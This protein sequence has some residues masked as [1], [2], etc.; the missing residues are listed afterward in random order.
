MTS[1]AKSGREVISNLTAVDRRLTFSFG[2]LILVLMLSALTAAV[3]YL[4]GVMKREEQQLSTLLTQVLSVSVSRVSFSGRYH[5]QLLLEDIL[6]EHP[7]IRYLR[8]TDSQGRVLAGN[9]E[10]LIDTPLLGAAGEQAR[11]ALTQSGAD[12]SRQLKMDGEPILEVTL[13]Y[14]GGFDHSIQGVVQV[15]ISEASRVAALRQGVFYV[16]GV[17]LLLLLIG[18]LAVHRLSRLFGLPVR[19]LAGDM[20][21]TLEALPDILFELDDQGR[22]VEVLAH[23]NELLLNTRDQLIGRRI[24][25]VLPEEAAQVLTEALQEAAKK[26]TSTGQQYSLQV[27]GDTYWFELSIARKQSRQNERPCFIVLA[28]DITDRKLAEESLYLFANA[29]KHSGEAILITDRENRIVTVNPALIR[30]TGYDYDELIGKNPRVLASGHASRDTYR[31]MWASLKESGY[32]QGE[33]WDRNKNGDVYPKWTAISVIRNAHNEVTHYIASYTD[34]TERKAAE[35]RIEFIAHHDVLTGLFN[36]YSLEERLEQTL[37][38]AHRKGERVAV[39][40]I[41]MDRF[42]NINDTLGHHSGDSLLVE[43]GRR[44]SREVR[45]SDI[46]ARLGGDEFIVVLNDV[47]SDMAVG[48]LAAQLVSRL[49]EAYQ[50]EEKLLHITASIGISMFP[51][52]GDD[53]ETLMKHADAAMYHAKDKGRNNFQFFTAAMNLA[54]EERMVIENEMR[55]ALNNGEFELHYQPISDA[56]GNWG[57]FEALLRWRHPQRGLIAPGLFIPIAEESRLI[58]PIG[59]WVIEEACRQS[60]EWQTSSGLDL[61]IA[62]NLSV[63]QLYSAELLGRVSK[64]LTK[65]DIGVGRLSFEVTESAAM[66]HPELAIQQLHKLR[67]MGIE[68]AIDDFGTGYSSLAYLKRLPIQTLKLDRTFVDDIGSDENDAAISAATVALAHNLGLEVVAEGVETEV[69]RDFL[70]AQGCDFLQGFLFSRP[71]PAGEVMSLYQSRKC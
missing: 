59:L 46:V 69:Q 31:E 56:A 44:L 45:S 39:M 40:F 38:S 7:N 5:A 26:G 8:V 65:Y 54:I 28:R 2:V 34:I 17:V 20:A 35:E 47:E 18:I 23:Q 67:D 62:V 10:S 48:G 33:L 63:H 1:S 14:R 11:L 16:I 70:V 22:Y 55:T 3:I 15:G 43:F 68:L 60:A 24:H 37:L 32:W 30:Y 52:D 25:E 19:Q 51:A 41:D 29:F 64:L 49:G 13:P 57:S 27:S 61:P 58:L 71:L 42:K 6:A 21:A 50:I 53:A 4:N 12:R 9:D 66:D 36:R